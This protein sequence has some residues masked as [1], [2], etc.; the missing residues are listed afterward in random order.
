[1]AANEMEKCLREARSEFD[2]APEEEE[3]ESGLNTEDE[4]DLQLRKACRLLEASRELLEEKSYYIIVIDACFT[5]IERSIQARLHEVN[6]LDDGEALFDHD[7]IYDEGAMAGIYSEDFGDSLKQLWS[8]N[9]SKN[10]YRSGTPSLSRA[11]KMYRLARSIHFHI[12]GMSGRGHKC[13]CK[14]DKK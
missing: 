6:I 11:R 9:R 14:V 5:A 12:T 7:S 8:E 4:T 3:I 10:Y 1:M 2:S 13:I